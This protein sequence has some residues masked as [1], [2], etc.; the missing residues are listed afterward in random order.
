MTNTD[1]NENNEESTGLPELDKQTK[2]KNKKK[3]PVVFFVVLLAIL[4]GAGYG[5]QYFISHNGMFSKKTVI[6]VEPP[7]PDLGLADSF[8]VSAADI[9]NDNHAV[10]SIDAIT[11]P[12]ASE[13]SKAELNVSGVDEGLTKFNE[14]I[15]NL[16]TQLEN[17]SEK[18][19]RQSTYLTKILETQVEIQ[20]EI[21]SVENELEANNEKL[22]DKLR[23]NERWLNGIANQLKEIGVTVKAANKEFSLVVF[24]K[25]VWGDSVY[26]TVAEKA[27][28][29]Q[30]RFFK[31]GDISG[32]WKLISIG[33]TKAIF[34]H[35]DGTKKEVQL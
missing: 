20:T 34:Q 24:S 35:F 7:V 11:S 10:P 15:E 17:F 21:K 19:D 14:N 13:K 33:E 18:I 3:P 26:L 25:N 8:D 29:E 27:H 2:V 28:P 6:P 12:V 31:I 23:S 32:R 22:A 4:G 30:T 5:V 16:N 1:V 9:I